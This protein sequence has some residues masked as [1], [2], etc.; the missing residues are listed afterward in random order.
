M[1]GSPSAREEAERLVATVLAM[2]ASSDSSGTREQVTAGLGALADTITG[3]V[4]RLAAGPGSGPAAG[5]A[6]SGHRPSSG[7]ATGSAECCVC[8]L[9][10]AIAAVR[11]PSPETAARLATGAGDIASG[12]ATLLRGFSHL[13]GD[14]P[15]P[16]ARPTPPPNPDETWQNATRTPD[17]PATPHTPDRPATPRTPDGR[18]TPRTPDGPATPRAAAPNPA[19]ASTDL[20]N[21]KRAESAEGAE[22]V[23]GAEGSATASMS[24]AAVPGADGGDR[25]AAG[26]GAEHGDPWAAAS[27]A[28]AVTAEAARVAS[29][30]RRNAAV[31]ARKAADVAARRVAEAAALATAAKAAA[32]DRA[33]GAPRDNDPDRPGKAARGGDETIDT[34][35]REPVSR[36]TSRG[37][38]VW[39]A[40]TS[41]PGVADVASPT[42]V[43]H[44]V[45]GAAAP[46]KRDG[47]AGDAAPGDGA[48]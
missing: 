48:A 19:A 28:D 2:A 18:A 47:A 45:P 3:V 6:A 43:D 33:G 31:A 23:S 29:R 16:A 24:D 30:E 14:R 26:S 44:D 12:L 15:K 34:S 27:A 32:A 4:G 46:G 40:A 37:L 38:D 39:A 36:R 41:E 20:T 5:S 42:T 13:A 7:W 11:D 17:R 22:V 9:C 35:G 25:W 21:P 10:K 8:P 1:S